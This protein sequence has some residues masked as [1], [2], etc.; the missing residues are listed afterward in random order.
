MKI[1][2]DREI[3]VCDFRFGRRSNVFFVFDKVERKKGRENV[4]G[5]TKGY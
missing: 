3:I 2:R 4:F 1:A 5:S